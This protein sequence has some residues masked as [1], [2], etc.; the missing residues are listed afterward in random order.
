MCLSCWTLVNSTLNQEKAR[1]KSCYKQHSCVISGFCSS[2]AGGCIPFSS[3]VVGTNRKR[4]AVKK[5][6][7]LIVRMK[8]AAFVLISEICWWRDF[9][10]FAPIWAEEHNHGVSF[11]WREWHL[12][13]GQFHKH[14][15]AESHQ[16][17]HPVQPSQP[18]PP[19]KGPVPSGAT[20][21]F[22]DHTR[23]WGA[24]VLGT[25][26]T[27]CTSAEGSRHLVLYYLVLCI[28]SWHYQPSG[29]LKLEHLHKV[30]SSFS[31]WTS[32]I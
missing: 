18:L 28:W 12:P 2:N 11:L 19:L 3:Q 6:L 8:I 24:Q 17:K 1:S 4:D 22:P 5:L 29:S 30:L 16:Y 9:W 21:E 23:T 10:Q 7:W 27:V 13:T 32:G 15:R 14:A 26:Y 25:G 31:T 20:G